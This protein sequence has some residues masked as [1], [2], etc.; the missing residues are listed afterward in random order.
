M[1]KKFTL[2]VF[3]LACVHFA[4]AQTLQASMMP[5]ITLN[6]GVSIGAAT[7]S[8][9]SANGAG[10]TWNFANVAMQPSTFNISWGPAANT[11]HHAAYPTAQYA[12]GLH[13]GDIL[14]DYIYMKMTGNKLE[15]FVD[16]VPT[17]P[18]VYI[19]PMTMLEFP[20]SLGN[21]F[22]DTYDEGDGPEQISVSYTGNGTLVTSLGT[23]TNVVKLTDADG[24]VQFWNTD[25]IYPLAQLDGSSFTLM[26]PGQG[27]GL[28]DHKAASLA[29]W[30]NPTTGRVQVEGIE[31]QVEWSLVDMLGRTALAGKDRLGEGATLDLAA[32]QPA[33]YRLVITKDDERWVFPVVKH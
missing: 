24:F 12:M 8:E 28:N 14:N 32:V 17:E 23:F 19:N 29:L 9:G 13:F 16:G 15:I 30:P 31:G 3:A 2:T 18:N 20:F 10:A 5:A 7:G 26:H 11:P 33:A 25:P 27:T 6:L 21:S 1:M 4:G 22:T